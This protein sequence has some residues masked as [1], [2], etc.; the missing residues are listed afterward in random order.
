MVTN[1]GNMSPLKGT[2][3]KLFKEISKPTCEA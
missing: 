1:T 2:C 3:D